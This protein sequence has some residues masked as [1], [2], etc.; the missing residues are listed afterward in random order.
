MKRVL[1]EHWPIIV[2]FAAI[3]LTA[4]IMINKQDALSEKM[5][6]ALARIDRLENVFIKPITMER[7]VETAN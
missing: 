4:G 5:D 7:Y 6:M 3:I 2:T 1:L